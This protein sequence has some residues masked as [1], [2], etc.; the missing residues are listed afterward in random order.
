M[1][2]IQEEL[3]DYL[4]DIKPQET[5]I[6]LYST[7]LGKKSLGK[8]LNGYYWWLNVRQAVLF[9]PAIQEILSDEKIEVWIELS[10]HPVLATSI[11]ECVSKHEKGESISAP[12]ISS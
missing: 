3:L 7:V 1:N 4:K 2:C 10:P 12:I 11:N 9:E 6:S 5:K 8:D